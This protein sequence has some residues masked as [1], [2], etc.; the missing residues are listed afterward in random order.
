MIPAD[1]L[2]LIRA[3]ARAAAERAGFKW[4]SGDG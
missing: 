3:L 2:D 4:S 1:V